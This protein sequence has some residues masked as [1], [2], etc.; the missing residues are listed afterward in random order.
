MI[1]NLLA[2]SIRYAPENSEVLVSADRVN[3][4]R[5]VLSVLSVLSVLDQGPGVH[6]KDIGHMFDMG[7]RGSAARAEDEGGAG[8]GIGLAIVRGI[9][10]AH[11]GDVSASRVLGGFR[12]DVTLPLSQEQIYEK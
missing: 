3:G 6:T 1:A 5:L 8:T 2:N 4:D 12:L 7:W 11:G 10:E 9:V